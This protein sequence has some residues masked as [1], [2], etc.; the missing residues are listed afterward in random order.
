MSISN[1]IEKVRK[2]LALSQSS[3]AHEAANAAAKANALIDEYR[4]SVDQISDV[5]SEDPII[6][7]Q[8]DPLY[9]ADRVMVWRKLLALKLTR[10]YGCYI[11]NKATA[12]GCFY[13]V[14]GRKSDVDVLRYMFAYISSECTRLSV[15]EAK[16]KG[17]IYAES[18]RTGFVDGVMGQLA[19]SRRQASTDQTAIVKL[20]DRARLAREHVTQSVPLTRGKST[21]SA[22]TDSSAFSSGQSAGRNM[23]FGASLSSQNRG[24]RLLGS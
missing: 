1:I 17:R 7:D 19:E 2:L 13:V 11:W 18:Y 3:N 24:A 9:Q 15:R 5:G 6:H 23:H 21:T 8:A 20:D 4:L 12:R 16:G 22:R 10:H 14:A